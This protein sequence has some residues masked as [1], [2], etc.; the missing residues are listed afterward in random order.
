VEHAAAPGRTFVVSD[1]E[2][3]SVPELVR[4]IARSLHVPARLFP[5][6]LAALRVALTLLGQ[7]PTFD[8]LCGSL[9]VDASLVERCLQW[10]PSVAVGS[11]LDRMARWFKTQRPAAG[12]P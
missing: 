10:R 7:R 9:F 8:R 11:E 3:L 5:M 1:G 2:D 4:Q 6:P 12:R